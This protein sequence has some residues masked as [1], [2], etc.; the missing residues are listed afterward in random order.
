MFV[1]EYHMERFSNA[2]GHKYIGSLADDYVHPEEIGR[3]EIY[4]D[5]LQI[6]YNH[7]YTTFPYKH[8]VKVEMRRG[9]LVGY[10]KDSPLVENHYKIVQMPD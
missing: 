2:L 1:V 10:L 7:L 4:N 9:E 3:A 8:M 6:A 5:A